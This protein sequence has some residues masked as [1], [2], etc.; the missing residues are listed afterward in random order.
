M[1]SDDNLIAPEYLV[2]R[3]GFKG[4]AQQRQNGRQNHHPSQK[5]AQSS[6][7]ADDDG[8]TGEADSTSQFSVDGTGYE[9]KTKRRRRGR[10]DAAVESVMAKI[11]NRSK[12][13]IILIPR[14][15]ARQAMRMVPL[16]LAIIMMQAKGIRVR[17]RGQRS[18]RNDGAENDRDGQQTEPSE[19]SVNRW[20]AADTAR[21]DGVS[22]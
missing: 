18:T 1:R 16:Q 14:Q 10:V 9:D 12:P 21:S 8:Q 7:N 11:I 4:K 6:D 2:E 15:V 20:A 17:G 3:E 5:A 19:A 22:R 13:P